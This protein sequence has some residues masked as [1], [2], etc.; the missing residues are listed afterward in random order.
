MGEKRN[1]HKS[2]V[3]NFKGRDHSEDDIAGRK[4]L[5]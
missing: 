3:G 1:A 2:L 4:T 5:K